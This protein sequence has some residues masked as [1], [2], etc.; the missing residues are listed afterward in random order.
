MK[1][2]IAMALSALFLASGCV[3]VTAAGNWRPYTENNIAYAL[4]VVH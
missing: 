2:I 1:T 4:Q 3:S